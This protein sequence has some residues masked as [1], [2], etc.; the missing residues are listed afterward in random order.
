MSAIAS[1]TRFSDSRDHAGRIKKLRLCHAFAL[2]VSLVAGALLVPAAPATAGVVGESDIAPVWSVHRTGE[3][4]LLTTET[5]QYVAYYDEDLYLSVAQRPVAGGNWSITQLPTQ[6]DW[7]TGR[8]HAIAMQ[9]DIAGHLH[10]AAAMHVEPLKYYRTTSPNDSSTLTRVASMVGNRE[11]RVSYPVF[12]KDSTG[13][14]FFMYRD[15]GSGNGSQIVNKYSASAGTWSRVAAPLFDGTSSG[16]NAYV[17]GPLRGPDGFFHMTW[18]W[19]NTSDVSTN[20]DVSYAKSADL[21]NWTT[22]AGQPVT[23]PITPQTAGVIADPVPINGGL[24]NGSQTIGFDSA[25][26]P[27]IA[28]IKYDPAGYTQVYLA[29]HDSTSWNIT[30]ATNWTYR[31]NLSGSQSLPSVNVDHGV[32]QS[33]NTPGELAFDFQH[34]I[35]GD[36]QIV[37]SE[38][39][40]QRVDTIRGSEVLRDWPER[41]EKPETVS[42]PRPMTVD[43]VPDLNGEGKYALRWERGPSSRDVAVALPWPAPTML[44]VIELNNSV[45]QYLTGNVAEGALVTA[46]SS[47]E[48]SSGELSRASLVDGQIFPRPGSLGYASNSSL[49][50]NH[51]EWVVLDLGQS[52]PIKQIS[53]FPATKYGLPVNYTLQVSVDGVAWATV[54]SRSGVPI[55]AGQLTDTFSPTNGRYVRLNAL[56]L[57]PN[58]TDR[59]QY[60]LRLSEIH[61]MQEV[62][63]PS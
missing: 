33:T 17:I 25:G 24:L 28:Y 45:E 59:N 61:V 2:A 20:H 15:G 51:A 63:I 22:V 46:S 43:I 57:R 62:P 50:V 5:T 47:L 30:K 37:V 8:H 12:V 18:V 10:V 58:P 21:E 34:V 55:S 29:R 6:S 32:I 7:S 13:V 53:I 27:I 19:R 60:R 42:P 1:V 14:L 54:A 48:K 40:L 3:P 38:S 23:L 31:W 9:I 4:V 36:G 26:Q 52:R 35:Y 39:D 56:S 16:Q 11:L 41:L 49:Q 44:R